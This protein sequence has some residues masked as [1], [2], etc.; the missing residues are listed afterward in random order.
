MTEEQGLSQLIEQLNKQGWPC[1]FVNDGEEDIPCKGKTV[2]QIVEDCAATEEAW[3]YFGTNGRLGNLYLVWG[4]SPS[5]LVADHS[6]SYGFGDAVDQ[7]LVAVWP[8]YPDV[9]D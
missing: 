4:N 1:A 9:E 7:A 8:T 2:A 5:E 3:L 6:L